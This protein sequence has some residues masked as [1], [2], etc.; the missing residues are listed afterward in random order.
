VYRKKETRLKKAD[1][2]ELDEFCEQLDDHAENIEGV[3]FLG[4]YG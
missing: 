4:M 2:S 1:A 3:E